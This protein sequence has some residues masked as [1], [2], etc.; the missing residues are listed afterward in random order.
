MK[1]HAPNL[2]KIFP[3]AFFGGLFVLVVQPFVYAR[4]WIDITVTGND[5]SS[6]LA[7]QYSPGAW[8]VLCTSVVATVLWYT[9]SARATI[10]GSKDIQKWKVYWW[11]IGLLPLTGVLVAI[12]LGR[13]PASGVP[14]SLVVFYVLDALVLFWLPTASSSPVSS[15]S[16]PPGSG[17]F[18]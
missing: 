2:L 1:N 9:L 3:I 4:Q 12:W 11:S 16:I 15:E 5:V 14:L 8:L 18:R 10:L 6:W 17:L 13:Q 7:E